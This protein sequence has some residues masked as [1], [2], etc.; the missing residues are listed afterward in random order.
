MPFPRFLLV[1]VFASLIG[2][3]AEDVKEPPPP[4]TLVEFTIIAGA[5]LNPDASHRASP[6]LF[7]IYELRDLAN[8]NGADFFALYEKEQEAIGGDLLRKQELTLVPGETKT[9][10]FEVE[11]DTRFLAVFAAFRNLEAA[12]WRASTPIPRAQTTVVDVK[13]DHTAITLTAAQ[14]L[15]PSEDDD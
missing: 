2:C 5:N 4:P 6:V 15:P 14:K 12:Q 3:G 7:R 9:L 13:L 1:L 8:F 10:S 11:D